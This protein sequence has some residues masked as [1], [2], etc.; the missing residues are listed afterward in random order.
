MFNLTIG[1]HGR[2]KNKLDEDVK[3][4]KAFPSTGKKA[5]FSSKVFS[6]IE[7]ACSNYREREDN[8]EEEDGKEKLKQQ[9]PRQS[10]QKEGE[11]HITL[12]FGVVVAV[13]KK[14]K[15][16][17]KRL[18]AGVFGKGRGATVRAHWGLH[19]NSILSSSSSHNSIITHDHST[20]DALYG[21]PAAV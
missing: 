6:V 2:P 4:L 11:S 1:K 10:Q 8:E 9:L 21:I 17:R 3:L 20:T 5:Q 19:F 14:K 15:R 7:N 12:L 16:K 18:E 13:K